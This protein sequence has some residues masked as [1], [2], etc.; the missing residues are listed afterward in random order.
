MDSW[1]ILQLERMK[2]GGNSK[3][4]KFWKEQKF[5]KNMNAKERYDNEAMQKYREHVLA[6]ARNEDPCSIP[7]IGYKRPTSLIS[8]HPSSS[9]HNSSMNSNSKIQQNYKMEGFG[10][11]DYQPSTNN[12]S[13]DGWNETLN[14]FGTWATG[15]ASKTSA[16][17]AGDLTFYSVLFS[18][19]ILY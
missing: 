17:A 8:N 3:L 14:S 19:H 7:F 2:N 10:N 1:S 6:L 16:A 13:N 9:M 18:V 15:F 5:P 4:K 11:T 12:E